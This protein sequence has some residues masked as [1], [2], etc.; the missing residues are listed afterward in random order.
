MCRSFLF[1]DL[2][3]LGKLYWWQDAGWQ[4]ST[5]ARLCQCPAFSHVVA[6]MSVL[7][8]LADI[9]TV[10]AAMHGWLAARLNSCLLQCPASAAVP[11]CCLRGCAE[12]HELHGGQRWVQQL[13][14]SWTPAQGGVAFPAS[15]T[16][17]ATVLYAWFE[18][19]KLWEYGTLAWT[20]VKNGPCWE[21]GKKGDYF[22]SLRFVFN[23]VYYFISQW[24]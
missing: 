6:Y 1:I 5:V 4:C 22:Y 7:S 9:C 8:A 13:F 21:K 11:R 3:N 2:G 18:C 24:I 12:L 15:W 23:H 14:R 20:E 16:K 10:C 17:Q 19:T